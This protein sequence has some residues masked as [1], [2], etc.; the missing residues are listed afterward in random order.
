[1]PLFVNEHFVILFHS[2]GLKGNTSKKVP[3]FD[4]IAVFF[5]KSFSKD[6]LFPIKI[7]IIA[8]MNSTKFM[9]DI[10]CP[11]PSPP[12]LYAIPKLVFM[13]SLV[14]RRQNTH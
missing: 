1:M 8:R 3:N 4:F 2:S 12:S 14:L 9:H 6:D 7:I 5:R 10:C 13:D 11:M